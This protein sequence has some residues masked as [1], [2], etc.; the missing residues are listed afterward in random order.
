LT[1]AKKATSPAEQEVWKTPPPIPTAD[2]QIDMWDLEA[3][4]ADVVF[5]DPDLERDSASLLGVPFA[6]YKVVYRPKRNEKFERDWVSVEMV[7]APKPVVEQEIRRG[8]VPNVESLEG[9]NVLPGSKVVVNDGS[10]GVRRQL[11]RTFHEAGVIDVGGTPD[12]GGKRFDREHGDWLTCEQNELFTDEDGVVKTVPTITKW[13]SGK[14]LFIP[15]RHGFRASFAPDY[16]ETP[17]YYL[18]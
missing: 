12:M 2:N 1:T 13:L 15:V 5:D 7:I 3:A 10:T 6:I 8:K 4:N 17:I 11:T 14:P 18:H 16:P 9:L